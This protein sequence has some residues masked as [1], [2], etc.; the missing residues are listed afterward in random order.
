MGIVELGALL[1]GEEE[2]AELP[3]VGGGEG[4]A[5]EQEK[6]KP[7]RSPIYRAIAFYKHRPINLA[8]TM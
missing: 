8:P 4:E 1:G 5:G 3:G 7:C 2:A 6:C